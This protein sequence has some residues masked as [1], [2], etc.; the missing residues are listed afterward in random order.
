MDFFPGHSIYGNSLTIHLSQYPFL[1]QLLHDLFQPGLIPDLTGEK[2]KNQDSP[3]LKS[4]LK[5]KPIRIYW[6]A[7]FQA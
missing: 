2:G 6:A 5:N 7:A 4:N 3:I 1:S